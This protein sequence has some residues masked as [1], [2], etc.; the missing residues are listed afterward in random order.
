MCANLIRLLVASLCLPLLMHSARAATPCADSKGQVLPQ[1]KLLIVGE[2]HGSQEIPAYVGRLLC[3]YAEQKL[4]VILHVEFP[5]SHQ[6]AFNAFMNE[7]DEAKAEKL[8]LETDK[9]SKWM[10]DGSTSR[11]MLDLFKLARKLRQSGTQVL[12]N[13]F[14]ST[15]GLPPPLTPGLAFVQHYS[16]AA[17]AANVEMRM[18]QYP[19]YRHLVLVGESHAEKYAARPWLPMAYR[20]SRL[21]PVRTL[22]FTFD[23]ADAWVC[24]GPKDKIICGATAIGP[25][26]ISPL[27]FDEVVHIPKLS[28]S[29]PAVARKPE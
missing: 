19:D 12:L 20:L 8:V 7:A 5:E 14:T 11:A 27:E 23:A 16:E 25:R 3:A 29:P 28:A 2:L 4:P 17:K 10:A 9:W 6:E 26:K 15:T 22:G 1:G 21:L 13:A 18:A 24:R